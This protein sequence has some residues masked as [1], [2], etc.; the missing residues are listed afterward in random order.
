MSTGSRGDVQ[1][2]I[3][4]G[5][6]LQKR[7][8]KVT[9]FTGADFTTFGESVGLESV[10]IRASNLNMVYGGDDVSDDRVNRRTTS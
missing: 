3:A 6:A 8:Y 1:P 2:Y 10:A 5:V 7:G 4:V 9:F